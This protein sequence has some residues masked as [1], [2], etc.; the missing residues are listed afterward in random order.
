MVG[1]FLRRRVSSEL[2]RQRLFGRAAL[3]RLDADGPTGPVM[4][5]KLVDDAAADAHAGVA[6]EWNSALGVEA[7]GSLGERHHA[8]RR[9]VVTAHVPGEPARGLCDQVA[10]EGKVLPDELVV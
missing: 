1:K 5:A 2:G 7:A 9:K 8:G 6:R 3:A 4:A 10:D